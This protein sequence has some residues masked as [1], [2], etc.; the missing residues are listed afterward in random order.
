MD[1]YQRG[2]EQAATRVA[3]GQEKRQPGHQDK[4]ES[5]EHIN[6]ACVFPG[7]AEHP[8]A[9]HEGDDSAKIG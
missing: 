9:D 4:T 3:I 5:P 8:Y 1:D 7:N 2:Y 6:N